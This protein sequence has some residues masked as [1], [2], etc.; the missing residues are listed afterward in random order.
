MTPTETN[1]P[2]LAALTKLVESFEKYYVSF[3]KLK[4]V[5]IFFDREL[6][7]DIDGKH[8]KFYVLITPEKKNKRKI[9]DIIVNTYLQDPKEATF[10][11]HMLGCLPPNPLYN[12]WRDEYM[13]VNYKTDDVSK[14]EELT[15]LL[16]YSVYTAV[17]AYITNAY[18][19]VV[20]M[21][22][23]P[24]RAAETITHLNTGEYKGYTK[25]EEKEFIGNNLTP[26]DTSR[27]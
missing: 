13:V 15:T 8:Y 24:Y 22:S 25:V 26:L 23:R 7:E 3:S 1:T 2:N 16:Y 11:V 12:F 9:F 20:T 17:A 10:K 21:F 27:W 18:K 14:G 19:P 4:E 6:G 5:K